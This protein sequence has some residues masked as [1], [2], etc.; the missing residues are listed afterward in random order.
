M[1]AMATMVMEAITMVTEVMAIMVMAIMVM[2]IMVMVAGAT[3]LGTK[4]NQTG[5][6]NLQ[7]TMGKKVWFTLVLII[8]MERPGSK[9]M[10]NL[11]PSM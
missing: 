4:S 3:I 8:G 2:A 5:G 7:K 11:L 1:A 10:M 6:R 9:I